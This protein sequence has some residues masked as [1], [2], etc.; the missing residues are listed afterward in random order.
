MGRVRATLVAVV[1][2]AMLGLAGCAEAPVV[3]DGT[4]G[5]DWAV[6]PTPSVPVPSAGGCTTAEGAFAAGWTLDFLPG[7][8]VECA[9]PHL[10][11]TFHVGT[12]PADVDTDPTTVPV[13]GT[14][15]FRYAYTECLDRAAQFL[16]GDPDASRLAVVPVFPSERQWAGRAR[17]FRCELM[18]LAGLDRRVA[19]RSG[20]LRDAL[21][22]EPS[23]AAGQGSPIGPLATTC[24][25]VTLD[26]RA[27]VLLVQAATFTSCE[28]PHDVELIGTYTVP[29]GEYPGAAAIAARKS[30]GC[31]AAGARYVGIPASELLRAGSSTYT[32][33]ADVSEEQWAAGVRS[34]WCFYGSDQPRSGSIRG[35]RAF[36]YES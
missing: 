10:A 7:T 8:E 20:S 15:R 6:L 26:D 27:D 4:L 14:V 11:E 1:S 35:L 13:V 36:P 19:G 28:R 2:A 33:A 18:E 17:W 34:G 30:S 9:S 31:A 12:F 16:G 25:D 21:A 3:G 32:F 23:S 24:A 22:A 5:E 29:D